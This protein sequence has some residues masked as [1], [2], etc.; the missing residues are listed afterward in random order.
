MQN[1]K[2]EKLSSLE[3]ALKILTTFLLEK[4]EWG[5]R[6][7]ADKLAFSPATVQRL[8]QTLR[9]YGFLDQD[10]STKKYRLGSIYF[11]Y[12]EVL[13]SHYPILKEAL[14]LMRVLCSQTGETTHLNVIDGKERLCIHSVES[15]QY[16]KASM[17]VGNRSP[18]YAGASSKCLLAF[19]PREFIESYLSLVDLIS[20]TQETI[21]DVEKLKAEIS[22]IRSRGYASSTGERTPGLCSI[23]VPIFGYGESFIAALSLAIPAVRFSDQR[24]RAMCLEKLMETGERLSRKMGYG[25]EPYPVKAEPLW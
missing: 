20:L 15:P 10:E 13:Q 19:S 11:R 21:T 6:D 23:S 9:S 3:K 24:H 12:V 8:V 25:G 18:L 4:P 7:L 14:P 1:I 16:L 2:E 17:P 5:I 22:L